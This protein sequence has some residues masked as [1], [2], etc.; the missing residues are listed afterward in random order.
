VTL[1]GSLLRPTLVTNAAIER[2]ACDTGSDPHVAGSLYRSTD[3][4][5]PEVSVT[6]AV[7]ADG[8]KEE[9]L[10]RLA[11]AVALGG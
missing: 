5:R 10:A 1:I 3:A 2:L 9:L 7:D 4:D 6:L 11:R 8:M